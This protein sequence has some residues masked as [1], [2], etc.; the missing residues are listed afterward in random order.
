L[1]DSVPASVLASP[2]RSPLPPFDRLTLTL[3]A[4]SGARRIV[5]L[6]RGEGKGE[7]VARVARGDPAAPASRLAGKG[8]AVLCLI[9]S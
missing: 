8:R 6:V 2:A 9:E 1:N 4:L 5:F 7:A 3:S